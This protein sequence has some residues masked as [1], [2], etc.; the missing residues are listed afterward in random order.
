M[1]L[2]LSRVKSFAKLQ[3][4]S[5]FVSSGEFSTLYTLKVSLPPLSTYLDY[6]L[7]DMI[8]IQTSFKTKIQLLTTKSELPNIQKQFGRFPL[9]RSFELVGCNSIELEPF[10]SE[11]VVYFLFNVK[12]EEV[13]K[14][15][16]QNVENY[17]KKQF[18][19]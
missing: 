17:L 8:F 6:F 18:K 9:L 11:G 10:I 5:K 13:L 16:L 4:V 14:G 12:N 7:N 19:K 15:P 3:N 1:Q 2:T